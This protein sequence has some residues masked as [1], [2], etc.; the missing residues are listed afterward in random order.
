MESNTIEISLEN[1]NADH[2]WSAIFK[3]GTSKTEVD[4][5]PSDEDLDQIKVIALIVGG[6][7]HALM[8]PPG[9]KVIFHRR[10][11]FL[12]TIPGGRLPGSDKHS[13]ILGMRDNPGRLVRLCRW[14]MR[15][16]KYHKSLIQI[17]PDGSVGISTEDGRERLGK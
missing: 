11:S 1:K 8:A 6:R 15:A 12:M 17:M 13:Y 5:F 9:W 14:L 16:P 3:D 2:A 4:T 10:N 7:D